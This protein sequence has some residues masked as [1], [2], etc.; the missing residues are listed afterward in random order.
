MRRG[1][2]LFLFTASVLALAVWLSRGAL[3]VAD[4]TSWPRRLGILPSRWAP[5]ILLLVILVAL[6]RARRSTLLVLLFP[7]I[8]LLPWLPIPVPAAA[9]IWT[10]HAVGWVWLATA[11]AVLVVCWPRWSTGRVIQAASDPRTGSLAALVLAF[12]VYSG[13]AWIVPGVLPGGEEPHRLLIAQRE[14]VAVFFALLSAVGSWLVWRAAH[15]VTR[16]GGAAWFGWASVA[17]SAPFCFHALTVDPDVAAATVVAGSVCALVACELD[18]P[19]EIGP[20]LATWGR[21]RW[22]LLGAV[23]AVL[24]WL[25]PRYAALEAVLLA[26][27]AL[28]LLGRRA[29]TD[30]AVLVG[31]PVLSAAGWLGVYATHGVS[32]SAAL[33]TPSALANIPRG[34]S[35]LVFDQSLGVLP[36]APAYAIGVLGLFWL[37]RARRRLAAELSAVLASYVLLVCAHEVAKDGASVPPPLVVPVLFVLGVPA[38]AAWSRQRSAGRAIS[39]AALAVTMLVSGSMAVA[40]SGSLTFGDRVGVAR[41]LDWLTPVVDLPRALPSFLRDSTMTA[42]VH[43]AIWVVCLSL[44]AVAVR[45]LARRTSRDAEA[46]T[47]KLALGTMLIFAATAMVAATATWSATRVGGATPTTSALSLLRGYDPAGRPVGV[48]LAPFGRVSIDEIPSRLSLPVSNRRIADGGGA[49]LALFDM[50]PG[51]YRLSRASAL[52]ALGSVQ[53]TVGTSSGPIARWSFDPSSRGADYEFTLPVRVGSLVVSGDG[54]A[55]RSMPRIALEP[56]SVAPEVWRF[57]SPPAAR[58]AAY[59]NM[60]AFAFEPDVYLEG[61]G[62]WVTGGLP[63]QMVFAGRPGASTVRLLVRNALVEN[64]ITL[65]GQTRIDVLHLKAGEVR[66][67][68]LP[69]DSRNRGA[70][71]E[72][73][74][75]RGYRPADVDKTTQDRRYLGVWIQ[76]VPQ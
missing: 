67:V 21:V 29:F 70:L 37:F 26:C 56:V 64:T 23:L 49:L 1:R 27:L 72:I 18:S 11:L 57:T 10:G 22:L 47:A 73:T 17:L 74:A 32:S 63:T 6:W 54:A 33:N 16:S 46:G 9:L 51:V 66:V 41:W 8:L 58:A 50:P 68:E 28:R 52:A 7:A 75:E 4:A 62:I 59:E 69:V 40:D 42:L 45:A 14:A 39:L 61:P 19:G 34:L 20:A 38:A 44:A 13:T 24:P 25:R 48:A 36:T 60:T 53:V 65:R 35:A 71:V 55:R 3:A 15:R 43:A 5:P 12:V 2:I 30:L 31:L 76:G